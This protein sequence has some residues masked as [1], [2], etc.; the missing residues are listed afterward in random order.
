ME[1]ILLG[2]AASVVFAV[3]TLLFNKF[4]YYKLT[5][6]KIACKYDGFGYKDDNNTELSELPI[7]SATVKHMFFRLLHIL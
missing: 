3:L 5:Y 2:L 7:S 4:L 6:G 1:S